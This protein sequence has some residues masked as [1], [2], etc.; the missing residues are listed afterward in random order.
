MCGAV[1]LLACGD[2]SP[3]AQEQKPQT[4]KE[5]VSDAKTS[6]GATGSEQTYFD[7]TK[8][9]AWADLYD[10]TGALVIDF[11]TLAAAKYTFGGWRTRVRHRVTRGRASASVIKHVTGKFLLPAQGTETTLSLRVASKQRGALTVYLNDK[12]LGH[13]KVTT[14]DGEWTVV[15]LGIAPGLIKKGDNVVQLRVANAPKSEIYLDWVRLGTMGPDLDELTSISSGRVLTL[16]KGW[17]LRTTLEVPNA[18]TFEGTLRSGQLTLRSQGDDKILKGTFR[19]HLPEGLTTLNLTATEPTIVSKAWVRV[20]APPPS[21]KLSKPLANVLVYLVDTA[22]ADKFQPWNPKT[23]VKTPGLSSF[24][25]SAAVFDHAHTQENWTKP[26]VAT[27]LT[28]L[29][30][31]QHTATSDD[32]VVPRSV[33]MLSETLRDSGFYTGAFIANGYVSGKFGFRQGWNTFRNY[34][35][36]GRRTQ[37]RFVATD[38]LDW[39]DKRPHDKRFFLYVHTIDPHVPYIPPPDLLKLYDPSPYDGPIDFRE[40]RELLEKI[41]R[42]SIKPNKRD[43]RR[44]EALYDGELS[45]HD[46]HFAS[47]IDALKKRKLHRDTVVVFT[48]DHGEE[49]FDHDSVGHGHSQYEELLHIPYVIRIPGID[50]GHVGYPVGLVDVVP[51]VLDALDQTPPSNMAGT[52]LLPLMRGVLPDAPKFVVSGFKDGWRTVQTKRY[53]LIQRTE[54]K[55]MLFD[56]KTDPD[57]QSPI[58][59]RPRL[60]RYMR[61]LMGL[62]LSKVTPKVQSK[63]TTIDASTEAQLRALGYV[64]SSRPSASGAKTE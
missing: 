45:Y 22:R 8:H 6:H 36:E 39:L 55:A 7:L 48:S 19:E 4:Q 16:P 37:A 11:G 15:Q 27:L 42:G 2:K 61:G 59:D 49:M 18:A 41:K 32:A 56:L 1:A 10:P 46:V 17:S 30:P 28:G 25:K 40:D 9:L 58:E 26:S 24:A 35:R 13:A 47:I 43:K 34:I 64:G 31:W 54:N 21:N 29:L 53:K 33:T 44:L 12:T 20:P 51:T 38:V 52:S 23:R 62:A 5:S 57:E 60:L 14:T 63:T 50:A 3:S